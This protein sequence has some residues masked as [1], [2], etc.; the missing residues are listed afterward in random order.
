M[1][2]IQLVLRED[3]TRAD[4]TAPV[5]LRITQDRRSRYLKSEVAVEPK[6][7]IKDKGRV[8]R[9]HPEHHVYNDALERLYTDAK[10]VSLDLKGARTGRP[11]ALAVKRELKGEGSSAFFPFAETYAAGQERRGKYWEWKKVNVLLSK[12]RAFHKNQDLSFADIDRTFLERFDQ[13]MREEK[14]NGQNTRAKNLQVLHRIVKAAVREGIVRPGDDPFYHF[15][16]KTAPTT[17][18]KLTIDEMEALERLDLDA[19][20]P[21]AVTRDAF[22]FSFYCAGVRFGDLCRLRWANVD[23][24]RLTYQMAKTGA[25]KDIEM[26]DEA[27]AILGRYRGG[28]A[29]RDAFVFPLLDPAL[30][31]SDPLFVRKEIASKNT[32]VNKNLK[33]LAERIGTKKNVS[34]HVARH[35]FADYFRG[36]GVDLYTISKSLGHSSLKITETYL[37]SFDTHAVDKAAKMGWDKKRTRK[38]E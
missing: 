21:L 12:L 35:S 17:K 30:D 29:S 33:E 23:G 28:G 16:V 1:A 2:T 37:N 11:S 6:Y 15:T 3:I 5:Y 27:E 38:R 25:P 34:F 26:P 36:A 31:Y 20:S 24:G 10:R 14:K 22:L 32:M 4:G 19:G 8:R 13:Y 18:E 7:W 9:S